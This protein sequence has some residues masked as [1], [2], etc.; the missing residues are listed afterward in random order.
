MEESEFKNRV[1]KAY[2][3]FLFSVFDCVLD[4]RKYIYQRLSPQDKILFL[5]ILRNQMEEEY[6]HKENHLVK[7]PKDFPVI[8]Y[9]PSITEKEYRDYIE[10]VYKK[11]IMESCIKNDKQ[12]LEVIKYEIVSRFVERERYNI[13]KLLGKI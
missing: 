5:N 11:E 8:N 6:S 7:P 1:N 4:E 3:D 9:I 12:R 13:R 10:K 2:H